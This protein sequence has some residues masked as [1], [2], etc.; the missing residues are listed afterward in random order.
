MQIGNKIFKPGLIPTI[1]TLLVLPVLLRL[2]FWQLERAEEKRDLIELFKKKN[3]SGPLLIKDKVNIDE[4]FN[5]RNSQVEGK[6]ISE[7]LIFI[8]NKIHQ[9]KSGVYVL[10][11]FKIKNSEYSILVNR[12]WVAMAADRSSL[13]QIQT[14]PELVTLSGKIKI[15]TEKPFTIGEQ[16]QSNQG[17]PALMQWINISEIEKKSD[18]KLLPYLFLLDEKEQSGYVRNWKP[19]VMLPEKSTSYAVQW[20][21]L[22]LALFIIYVVVNLKKVKSESENGE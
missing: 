18:L 7:K 15:L 16:F 13:P 22:A 5:Y 6:Y 1:I 17:W 4:H 19:V 14:T 8:D 20:F 12:G 10:T 9:G 2:G 21:S 11:P 3:D